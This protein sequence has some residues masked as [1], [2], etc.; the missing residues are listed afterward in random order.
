V[1]ET[2]QACG[3]ELVESKLRDPLQLSSFGVGQLMQAAAQNVPDR[4]VIGLGGSA[5]VDGGLGLLA[6]LGAVITDACDR[7]IHRGRAADLA[8]VHRLNLADAAGW[9]DRDV[10]VLCDVTTPLPKSAAA[11]GPQKGATPED[12]RTL[13]Q[14]LDEWATRVEGCIGR[15]G[16]RL[17]PGTGAAGGLGFAFRALG[18][19][20][21]DGAGHVAEV[22]GLGKHLARADLVIVGEGQLD[23]TSFAGKAVGNAVARATALGVPVAAVVGRAAV[24][25]DEL[26]AIAEAG[27]PAGPGPYPEEEVCDAGK[28]LARTVTGSF[29]TARP[30]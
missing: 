30:R 19:T 9:L 12:V 27:G 23:A 7:R 2:A 16:L 14:L 17:D 20:M 4:Y 3:L 10:T 13:E 22:V 1:I 8:D 28:R 6:A 26:V 11:F 29:I 5:T 21:V 25:P 15:P 24:V 18:A